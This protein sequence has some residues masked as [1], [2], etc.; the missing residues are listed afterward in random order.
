MERSAI[1]VADGPININSVDVKP[2]N[3]PTPPIMALKASLK[4]DKMQLVHQRSRQHPKIYQ[5]LPHND[6]K[7]AAPNTQSWD[8]ISRSLSQGRLGKMRWRRN[9][10]LIGTQ[11]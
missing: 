2:K 5:M 7:C 4:L 1:S 10:M 6:T 9:I 3:T 11:M 8:T